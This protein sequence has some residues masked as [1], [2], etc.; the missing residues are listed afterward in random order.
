MRFVRSRSLF[1]KPLPIFPPPN[2]LGL[3][4]QGI[5]LRL[6]GDAI[7]CGFLVLQV[8][9]IRCKMAMSMSPG[10][11]R[12]I[13]ENVLS[14]FIIKYK[15]SHREIPP[16][17]GCRSACGGTPP[18]PKTKTENPPKSRLDIYEWQNHLEP[19]MQIAPFWMRSMPLSLKSRLR[20]SPAK[21]TL[22]SL[23]GLPF[24]SC[25]FSLGSLYVTV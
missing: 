20:S 16:E 8:V 6:S 11:F 22:Q 12:I 24:S 2:F 3:I 15:H 13:S 25:N 10:S 18:P 21:V 23:I 9:T 5:C 7:I 4:S 17:A 14:I 1:H 19:S